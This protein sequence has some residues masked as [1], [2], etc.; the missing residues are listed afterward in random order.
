M[1]MM[2]YRI[3]KWDNTMNYKIVWEV[4][5]GAVNRHGEFIIKEK[6][7]NSVVFSECVFFLKAHESGLISLKELH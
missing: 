1:I 2:E 6:L 7:F 3:H 4:V 5:I